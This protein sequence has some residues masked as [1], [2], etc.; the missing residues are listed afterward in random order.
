MGGKKWESSS[1]GPDWTDVAILMRAI[2]TLHSVL[3]TTTLGPGVFDGPSMYSTVAAVR[4][5]REANVLGECVLALSA[6]FPCKEHRR[7]EDCVFAGLYQL[8]M[9]LTA[10]LWQQLPLPFTAG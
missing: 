6:E 3:V 5:P 10:K 1:D 9:A 8:D 4:V 2:E 7:L